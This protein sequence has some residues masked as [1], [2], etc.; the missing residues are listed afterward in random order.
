MPARK[1]RTTKTKSE[2]VTVTI[3]KKV[4]SAVRSDIAILAEYLSTPIGGLPVTLGYSKT[5]RRPWAVANSRGT[6]F[7]AKTL[8]EVVAE[9]KRRA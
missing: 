7:C 2:S 5:A 4:E 9:A 8:E 3:S 6:M 1:K